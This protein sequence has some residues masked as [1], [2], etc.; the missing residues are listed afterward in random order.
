MAS[1]GEG[2]RERELIFLFL[3]SLT[4]T[5]LASV[6]QETTVSKF[7]LIG[8]FLVSAMDETSLETR[9]LGFYFLQL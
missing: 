1:E 8:L 6:S 2:E 5:N 9:A 3:F 4:A 7:E